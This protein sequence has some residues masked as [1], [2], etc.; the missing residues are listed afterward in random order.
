MLA[1]R[2]SDISEASDFADLTFHVSQEHDQVVKTRGKSGISQYRSG[3][4]NSGSH[5]NTKETMKGAQPYE[6][7]LKG[8]KAPLSCFECSGPHKKTQS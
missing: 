3:Y 2:P 5:D 8:N 4:Q 1:R 7:G 6:N